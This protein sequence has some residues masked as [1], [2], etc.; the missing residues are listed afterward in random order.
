MRGAERIAAQRG[1]EV[2][3]GDTIQVG[4][5]SNTQLR[6]TDDSI[7]S[8]RPETTF[9]LTEYAFAGKKPEEQRAFYN[10]VAGGVDARS[11]AFWGVQVDPQGKLLGAG[12]TVGGPLSAVGTAL[13]TINGS[14]PTAGNLVWGNWSG[15][16]SQITDSNYASFTT[17]P[18]AFVPWITGTAP[19]TLPPSLG[20]LTYTPVGNF[21]QGT[22]VLNSASLTADFVARSLSLGMNATNPSA[23]NTFQM[24][25]VTGFSTISGRFSAGFNTVTCSGPCNSGGTPGGSFAGFFAGPNAEGAGLVFST[26]FG[27][28]GTGVTGVVG[29]KR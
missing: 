6:L 7:I 9:R 10:L 11:N 28:G 20:T 16:G 22:G 14:A 4:A 3:T 2:R 19:N 17:G 24:N 1:T 12:P 29:F 15:A 27:T 13:N 26:G 5:Q 18:T 23:G 25:A 21:M 8:L